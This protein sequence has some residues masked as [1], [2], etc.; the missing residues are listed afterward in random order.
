MFDSEVEIE[1]HQ[2]EPMQRLYTRGRDPIESRFYG[3]AIDVIFKAPD[4]G[5]WYAYNEKYITPIG[6][7]PFCGERLV[8]KREG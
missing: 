5:R 1:T 2:C 7:C 6:F 3:H 8:R 4:T